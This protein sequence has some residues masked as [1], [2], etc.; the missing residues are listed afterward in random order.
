[1][2]SMSV[3]RRETAV[4]GGRSEEAHPDAAL[5]RAFVAGEAS[6]VRRVERWAW[7]I[8]HFRWGSIPQAD[9]AD[10]VQDA[11]ADVWRAAS[12]PGFALRDSL[13]ALVRRVAAARCI[14][15]MRKLRPT[16]PL[17]DDWADVSDNP[18]EA[19]LRK[20][21]RARLRWVL[22]ALDER[23]RE[24]IREHF[25]EELPYAAIAQRRERSEATMRVHMFHCMKRIRQLWERWGQ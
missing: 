20:S 14:D 21:D 11:V 12:A 19:L 10:L 23:C 3:P 15:W 9:R 5:L 16:A 25:Y 2:S 22:R 13:R 24:I 6:A 1:M 18:Y 8:V 17:G 7:E 4:A